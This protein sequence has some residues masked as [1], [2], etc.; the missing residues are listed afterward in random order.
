MLLEYSDE[1]RHSP[2][3]L[4]PYSSTSDQ[5]ESNREI[6]GTHFSL[7]TNAPATSPTT[8]PASSSTSN[9]LAHAMR[10]QEAILQGLGARR[11]E[12]FASC[13]IPDCW[14]EAADGDN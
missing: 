7:S 9:K 10:R 5:K 2:K 6:E 8:F 12:N 13:I 1:H 4:V 14:A 11:I 3:C